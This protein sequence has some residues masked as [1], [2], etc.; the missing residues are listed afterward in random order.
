MRHL[1]AFISILIGSLFTQA[2]T[3][4]T[5][6]NTNDSGLGSLRAIASSCASGDIIRFSPT[7]IANGS[8]SIVLTTGE[9][10]FGS[11]G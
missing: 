4:H 6:I 9:I 5:V 7:L 8:D 3:T 11:F 1:I 10:A 2:Q